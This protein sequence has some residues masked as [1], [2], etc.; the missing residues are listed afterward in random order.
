MLNGM[1]LKAMEVCITLSALI[2][3]AGTMHSAMSRATRNMDPEFGNIPTGAGDRIA[4]EWL[5]KGQKLRKIGETEIDRSKIV[6]V[7]KFYNRPSPEVSSFQIIV[8]GG[9][10][11]RREHRYLLQF[12]EC[13]LDNPDWRVFGGTEITAESFYQITKYYAGDNGIF[14]KMAGFNN[15]VKS[16]V[17][18]GLMG[19]HHVEICRSTH[20][21]QNI[22]QKKDYTEQKKDHTEQSGGA[23]LQG[24]S[25]KNKRCCY[26]GLLL[27]FMDFYDYWIRFNQK[28]NILYF[29]AS[30]DDM[31]WF[32]HN[33]HQVDPETLSKTVGVI[34]LSSNFKRDLR[35][36]NAPE[37]RNFPLILKF[38]LDMTGCYYVLPDIFPLPGQEA[39]GTMSMSEEAKDALK[40]ESKHL[41]GVNYSYE[42]S[43]KL[44]ENSLALR[45]LK[46]NIDA[47]TFANVLLTEKTEP[48]FLTFLLNKRNILVYSVNWKNPTKDLEAAIYEKNEKGEL[49]HAHKVRELRITAKFLSKDAVEFLKKST[50]ILR[51]SLN[52]QFCKNQV[53]QP[54]DGNGRPIIGATVISELFGADSNLRKTVSNLELINYKLSE[55]ECDILSKS[56]VKSIALGYRDESDYRPLIKMLKALDK[57]ESIV[58]G[59]KNLSLFDESKINEINDSLRGAT[60]VWFKIAV[61]TDEEKQRIQEYMKKMDYPTDR[62]FYEIIK[63]D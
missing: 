18:K 28:K 39:A 31:G 47:V 50:G 6:N 57:P 20:L 40:F 36:R 35:I 62:S 14:L 52:D 45:A 49:I 33:E 15:F 5:E 11:V 43:D 55:A 13:T 4:I 51:L 30:V 7:E 9:A 1:K 59:V 53:I 19:S 2:A 60:S 48:W 46:E 22:E 17:M 24:I 41:F 3:S 27:F 21:E 34:F 8:D 10:D 16:L 63:L 26:F 23:K 29:A 44:E 37:I 54:L 38:L 56:A 58:I 32:L 42:S 25:M 12:L 61:K